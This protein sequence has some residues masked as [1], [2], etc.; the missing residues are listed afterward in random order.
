MV[1]GALALAHTGLC[2]LFGDWLIGKDPEPYLAAPLDETCHGD[3]AGFDLAV[4]DVPAFNDL[5]TKVAER[6]VG[7]TP[8][9][10]A[11]AAAL[12][13]AI[14]DLLWHQHKKTYL[15]AASCSHLARSS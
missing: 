4:G 2:R 13:L 1:R 7:S 14:F 9:L 11:H 8:C 15:F 12:L 3:T 10:A 6:K 5:E